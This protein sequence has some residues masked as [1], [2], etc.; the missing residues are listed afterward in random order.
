MDEDDSRY[1]PYTRIHLK[2]P[3]TDPIALSAHLCMDCG[4]VVVDIAVHDRF[5]DS[6]VTRGA[7]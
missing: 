6:L 3:D 5:H 7:A 4:A 2:D 1:D